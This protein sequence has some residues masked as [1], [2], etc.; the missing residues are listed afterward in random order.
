MVHDILGQPYGWGGLFY[1]RDCSAL[2]RD[3]VA[4]FGVWL[5]RNSAAQAKQGGR[6]VSLSALSLEEKKHRIL[7]EGKPFTT[8]LWLKG[9]IMVYVGSLS[10]EPMALHNIWA[11]RVRTPQGTIQKIVIGRTVVT[12]LEP[13]SML[14]DFDPAQSL[15]ARIEGMTFLG[16]Q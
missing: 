1:H 9:H 14:P 6:F 4:P 16:E 7:A 13:G 15:L 5:P 11:V 8:L 10:G 2:V 12:D 3:V